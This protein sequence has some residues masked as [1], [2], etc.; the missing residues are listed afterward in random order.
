MWLHNLA[1]LTREVLGTLVTMSRHKC[2]STYIHIEMYMYIWCYFY[3]LSVAE[4][5]QVDN[6]SVYVMFYA[7]YIIF[8]YEM[9]ICL[10]CLLLRAVFMQD[11]YVYNTTSLADLNIIRM[12]SHL[13][14][15]HITLLSVFIYCLQ[16]HMFLFIFLSKLTSYSRVGNF[17][18]QWYS[19]WNSWAHAFWCR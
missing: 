5:K 19:Q 13:I 7:K 15:N 3:L 10:I 18:D 14:S 8:Q 2:C 6:I 12:A 1:K 17:K 4:H 9:V 11:S 16:T